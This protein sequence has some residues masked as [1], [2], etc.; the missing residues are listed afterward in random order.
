MAMFFHSLR[1]V[2]LTEHLVLLADHGQREGRE[3]VDDAPGL[4]LPAGHRPG[5]LVLRSREAR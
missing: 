2:V 5:I 4:L 3:L 1:E